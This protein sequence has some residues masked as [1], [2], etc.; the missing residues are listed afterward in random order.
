L[1]I[2]GRGRVSKREMGERGETEI[3]G[4]W[5]KERN[6]RKKIKGRRGK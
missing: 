2:E 5:K 6:G 1:E 4:K 3:K